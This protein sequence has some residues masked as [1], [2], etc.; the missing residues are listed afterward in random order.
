MWAGFARSYGLIVHPIVA[1]WTR[2]VEPADVERFL[3][4]HPEASAVTVPYGE[5]SS[6]GRTDIAAVSRV[7]RRKSDV[8]LLVDG[9][10]SI[11]GMPFSFDEWGVDVAVTASQ[12]CLMSSPGVAFA[13]LGDRAWAARERAT[14]PC[15]YWNFTDIRRETTKA[16][17]ET[18]GTAPVHLVLQVAEALRMIHD[19]GLPAVF[20]RHD[21]MA[22]RA[23]NGV[24]KLGLSL[25]SPSMAARSSTVTGVT[26]PSDLTPKAVRDELKARGILVAAGMGAF[27]DSGFRIGH[28]G[29]IRLPDV[30]RTLLALRE[31]LVVATQ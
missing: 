13:V 1:D 6:G 16:K 24:A 28:M 3:A 21:A 27:V 8:L 22:E 11:G 20:H 31:A 17:P 10:S 7:V 15:N 29:D 19:E 30:D 5:T 14:L 26:L 18:P 23:R 4:E 9:V 25:Q 2:N 12:K